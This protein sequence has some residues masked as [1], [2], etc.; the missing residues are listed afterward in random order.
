MIL[1]F[2]ENPICQQL[3]SLSLFFIDSIQMNEQEK[4]KCK[5]FL[6]QFLGDYLGWRRPVKR[7]VS[8]AFNEEKLYQKIAS[9]IEEN[10]D[11]TDWLIEEREES[12]PE[13]VLEHEEKISTKMHFLNDAASVYSYLPVKS[14]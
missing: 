2:E 14:K 1:A 12:P 6:N 3:Y 10:L 5:N 13:G 8:E 11:T 4:I 7:V 9:E